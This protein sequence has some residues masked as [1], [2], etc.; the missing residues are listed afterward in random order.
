M[1]STRAGTGGDYRFQ[2]DTP[3]CRVLTFIA[4][5]GDTFTATGSPWFNREVCPT[6]GEDL[7]GI[8][9]ELT[10]VD[11][12]ATVGGRVTT[13]SGDG[14]GALKAVFYEANA[15]GTR[16]RWMGDVFTDPTGAYERVVPLGCY[17]VD[18]VAPDG[19]LWIETGTPWRQHRTCVD[20][21]GSD[22]SLDGTLP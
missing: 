20:A 19:Q 7:T 9:A 1:G 5:P 8:D 10:G 13:A 16:G 2:F 15:D 4:P 21:G 14:V 18:L 17:I 11:R 12:A 22:R 3:G 6:A